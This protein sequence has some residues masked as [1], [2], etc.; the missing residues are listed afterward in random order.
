VDIGGTFTDLQILDTRQR[1][2]LSHKVPTT[3][4]DPSIGLITGLKEAAQRHGLNLRDI[5][6]VVHG[7]TIATN[8]VLERKFPRGALVT[9]K[10]FEDVLEIGRHSRREVYSV[11]PHP[12]P[13]LIE[14]KLRF[15]VVERMTATGEVEIPLSE[16]ALLDLTARLRRAEVATVAVCL[17][18]AYVNPGHEKRIAK[19]LAHDLPQLSVSISS[20][21]S[22]DP[23]VR[24]FEYDGA[25][26]SAHPGCETLP[27]SARSAAEAGRA[28]GATSHCAIERGRM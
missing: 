23:R 4:D 26:C 3:L 21:V 12:A 10:G 15:G 16:A 25:Q 13:A 6:Y 5:G 19:R 24:A 17:V 14:R 28:R 20:E 9:T 22:P 2:T 11:R 1:L 18:N 8:A 27:R 7:T